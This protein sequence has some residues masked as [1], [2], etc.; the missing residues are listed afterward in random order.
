MASSR[1]SRAFISSNENVGV[2]VNVDVDMDADIDVDVDIDIRREWKI[3]LILT[4]KEW[5]LARKH[6]N[7]ATNVNGI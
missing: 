7:K 2:D 5:V 1:W 6:D 4:L 3:G